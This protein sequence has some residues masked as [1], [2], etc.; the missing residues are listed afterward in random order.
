LANLLNLPYDSATNFSVDY[1]FDQQ[2]VDK[3]KNLVDISKKEIIPAHGSDV[4][5]IGNSLEF[6]FHFKY[7]KNR[8]VLNNNNVRDALYYN[9]LTR[10]TFDFMYEL[11]R[12]KLSNFLG[13][14]CVYRDDI[15]RP[16]IRIW[17]CKSLGDKKEN[18]LGYHYDSNI[19]FVDWEKRLGKKIINTI[20][21]TIA[22]ELPDYSTFE[23]LDG[24]QTNDPKIYNDPLMN[25]SIYTPEDCKLS[26]ELF[27]N[28]KTHVYKP[29][30]M[31]IQWNHTLHRIGR[32]RY[33]SLNQRRITVQFSGMH[34]GEKIWLSS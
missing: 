7:K 11:I 16:Y 12:N 32:M 2:T 33:T 8:V 1:F 28:R 30:D 15:L 5:C 10:P 6:L 26:P 24:S 14:P 4:H 20:S 34:D 22:I 31:V 25:T 18:D 27:N 13:I 21:G 29:G 17:N 23:W 3:V 9:A 19:L